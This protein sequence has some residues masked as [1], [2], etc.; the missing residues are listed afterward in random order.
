MI[1]SRRLRWAGYVVIVEV[2]SDFQILTDNPT[3]KRL[4]GKFRQRWEYNISIDLKEFRCQFEE[5][6]DW[7]EDMDY[8]RAL[9]KAA[10][11]LW[12]HKPWS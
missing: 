9:V 8:W 5:L 4:V 7:A 11:N 6:I 12:V 1:K 10:L 3:R 2:G